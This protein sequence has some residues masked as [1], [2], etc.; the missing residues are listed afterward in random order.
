LIEAHSLAIEDLKENQLFPKFQ[1]KLK[2]PLLLRKVPW[3]W[4]YE[5]IR[6]I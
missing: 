3:L 6:P 2:R 5:K 1:K 4:A